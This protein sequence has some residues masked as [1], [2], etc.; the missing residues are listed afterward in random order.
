MFECTH[1]MKLLNPRIR[2]VTPVN[3]ITASRE[4]S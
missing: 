1:Q 2:I 4:L 3:W